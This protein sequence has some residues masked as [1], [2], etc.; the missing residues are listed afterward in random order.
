MAP[1]EIS[2]SVGCLIIV[3]SALLL[4]WKCWSW[5]LGSEQV[6]TR[7]DTVHE[8]IER[9]K[10]RDAREER[11]GGREGG[12]LVDL[13]R[14]FPNNKR[15]A[16]VMR[17]K[18]IYQFSIECSWNC[19]WKSLFRGSVALCLHCFIL[20]SRGLV[21]ADG[22]SRC[23]VCQ[24]QG[25]EQDFTGFWFVDTKIIWDRSSNQ[26]FSKNCMLIKIEGHFK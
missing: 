5:H 8:R 15:L 21:G 16:P 13:W 11:N 12:N 25:W 22:G 26:S 7:G 9:Q 18:L 4:H 1:Q 3:Q 2:T 14:W 19:L 23:L 17:D 6:T 20:S 24:V 10:Q